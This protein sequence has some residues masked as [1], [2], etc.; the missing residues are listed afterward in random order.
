MNDNVYLLFGYKIMHKM[1]IIVIKRN[2]E[3]VSGLSDI[4]LGNIYYRDLHSACCF[5]NNGG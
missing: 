5:R 1:I 3:K 2:I 4:V